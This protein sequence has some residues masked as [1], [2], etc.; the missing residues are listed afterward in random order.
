MKK[1]AI[2]GG[3]FSGLSAASY[4]AKAGYTVTIFEKNSRNLIKETDLPKFASEIAILYPNSSFKF[5]YDKF[6]V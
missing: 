1:I 6:F 2:I 4:L 5:G 3:G